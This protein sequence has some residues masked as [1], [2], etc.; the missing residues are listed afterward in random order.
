MN[1][2][3]E[4]NKKEK[5]NK[6]NVRKSVFSLSLNNLENEEWIDASGFAG[7]LSNG[8]LVDRRYFPEATPV[9]KN[10][11]FGTSKPKTNEEI[12]NNR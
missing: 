11:I 10:S 4:Q 6:T 1:E 2:K 12:R 5:L 8:K 9:E 3:F 7:V